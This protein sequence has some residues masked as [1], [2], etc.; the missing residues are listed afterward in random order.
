MARAHTKPPP[1]VEGYVR[2][3]EALDIC[4]LKKLE[5]ENGKLKRMIANISLKKNN[6][7]LKDI[8]TKELFLRLGDKRDLTDFLIHRDF[9]DQ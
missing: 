5:G 8:I 1:T 6:E 2:R 7:A 9:F 3:I 4:R